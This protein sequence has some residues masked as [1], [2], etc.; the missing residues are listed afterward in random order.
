MTEGG[1]RVLVERYLA[2]VSNFDFD[3]LSGL[4]H[5]DFVLDWPQTGE[6]IRGHDRDAAMHRDYPG[7]LPTG[8]VRDV[9]GSEDRWIVDPMFVPRRIR[10]EGDIW[11]GAGRIR[12]P[13]GD[14]WEIVSLLELRDG[15]VLHETQWFAPVLP[16]PDWRAP[17][18]EPFPDP[19]AG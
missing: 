18:V 3:T 12:Y 11:S 17:W 8:A 7:G 14:L 13:D 2:A 9:R 19:I 6:R 15:K 1:N 16:A 5:P 10:G 4:R